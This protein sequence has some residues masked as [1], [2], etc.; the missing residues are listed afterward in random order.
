MP[1]RSLSVAR[2]DRGEGTAPHFN[3]AVNLPPAA[4]FYPNTGR[5]VDMPRLQLRLVTLIALTLTA[6]GI[7]GANLQDRVP[8]VEFEICIISGHG[9]SG[10]TKRHAC[11]EHG[12]P[13]FFV[14]STT[15]V[16][17]HGP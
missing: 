14:V 9:S 12:C 4:T 6:G 3:P 17:V 13:W 11:R 8:R 2:P 16:T 7:L 5:A 1:R 15:T 10:W